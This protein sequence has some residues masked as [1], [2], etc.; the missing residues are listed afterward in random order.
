M[1]RLQICTAADANYKLQLS[2]LLKSLI[3]SQKTVFN[4]F[5]MGNG[6]TEKD[7]NDILTI[8]TEPANIVFID[9]EVQ[10]F[11]SVKLSGKFPLATIY[12][13][14]APLEFFSETQKILYLDCDM[15]VQ[16]DLSIIWGLE[17]SESVA[18]VVDSH[19]GVN[20]NPSMWRPWREL[21][22]NPISKYLNTGLLLINVKKWNEEKITDKCVNLL[23][24]FSLPC[25]DQDALNLVLNGNFY[26]LPPRFNS[27]PMHFM[28]K[29]RYADLIE[30]DS[31]ILEAMNNPA[32]IHFHRSFFGKPWNF[33]STHPYTKN[34]RVLAREVKP[35][36]LPK[37]DWKEIAR[38]VVA[39][40][41]GLSSMDPR[42]KS[43]K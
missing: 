40:V 22:V 34:W 43:S 16:E 26:S 24:K 12:N 28:P 23:T 32:I 41:L 18:A 17:F 10:N 15:V 1:D 36:W 27:M 33:G 42:F 37:I 3:I 4:F 8:S 29:L 9:V 6:W 14:L 25:L 13:L 39:R 30:N 7:K 31:E 20:G 19:V 35:N 5:V 38:I 11:K 2:V 21:N